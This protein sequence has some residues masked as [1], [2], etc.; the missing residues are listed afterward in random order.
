VARVV[1]EQL[2]KVFPGAKGEV[3]R[4]L[5]ELTLAVEDGELLVLA[6]PSGC[7]KTSTLRLVAGLEEP[8]AGT[9][10]IGGQIV[11]GVSPKE[12][13]AAMVFQNPALYP[14]LTAYENLAFGLKLRR[15]S[16]P[17][18]ERRVTEAA[19]ML[20]LKDCLDRQ[21][22]EL[23]G[24]ERQR[25]ALGR[26]IVRRPKVFLLDEPL[27]NLDAP[28]RAQMRAEISR[29]HAQLGTTMIYV[30]HEQAEAMAMGDRLAVMRA[31]RIEQVDEPLRVYQQPVNLFVAG[32]IG[33]P[34]INTFHGVIIEKSGT[35]LFQ[36][37]SAG[38]TPSLQLKLAEGVPARLREH[39]GRPVVLALRPEHIK[40]SAEGLPPTVQA[41]VEAVEPMGAE[42]YLRVKVGEYSLV[43][44]V[45]AT[46]S[47]MPN[48]KINLALD[49]RHARFFEAETGRRLE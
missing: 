18:I 28:M 43:V 30:T 7:G 32:F 2:T 11:N 42:S 20:D 38:A 21:P 1:L 19:E 3:V 39:A 4:A 47:A 5:D 46:S 23:S 9:I 25:V 45:P 49:L 29:L 35:L 37:R 14:H 31:G 44:R 26:A 48:Q 36:A 17:E 22:M 34:P 41:L 8:T 33:A 16:K 6:G 15:F 27:S 13:D 12:R 10:S 40:E 24:G